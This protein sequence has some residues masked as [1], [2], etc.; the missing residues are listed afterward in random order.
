MKYFEKILSLIVWFSVVSTSEGVPQPFPDECDSKTVL[1]F[2]LKEGLTT[3]NTFDSNG[4]NF[5]ILAHILAAGNNE[6]VL[7][8]TIPGGITF[9]APNDEAIMRTMRDLGF[10]GNQENQ[11]Y[12]D[13]VTFLSKRFANPIDYL[14]RMPL[15]HIVAPQMTSTAIMQRSSFATFDSNLPLHRDGLRLIDRHPDLPDAKLIPEMQ[16]ICTSNGYIHIIDR[17]LFSDRLQEPNDP[18]KETLY[19]RSAPCLTSSQRPTI[20]PYVGDSGN[21]MITPLVSAAVEN[22]SVETSPMSYVF[23][24]DVVESSGPLV[25]QDAELKP[26]T[27]FVSSVM[28]NTLL[29][30]PRD[31]DADA[32]ML[33]RKAESTPTYSSTAEALPEELDATPVT[34]L[35]YSPQ[36]SQIPP[37]EEF[38]FHGSTDLETSPNASETP[39]D[40]ATH[41]STGEQVSLLT[42]TP[43]VIL[44]EIL[45]PDHHV[46]TSPLVEDD[47][48]IP[49]GQTTSAAP[50]DIMPAISPSVG[51]SS[52]D[53][54]PSPS[55]STSPSV[56]RSIP[57]TAAAS[58]DI[59]PS[60]TP[61]MEVSASPVFYDPISSPLIPL[62]DFE[63]LSGPV[64]P[65]STN[66]MPFDLDVMGVTGSPE[67]IIEE[68]IPQDS[69][70]TSGVPDIDGCFPSSAVIH[71]SSGQ[72]IR[73]ANLEAGHRIMSSESKSST[74]YLFS[75][76]Q[77][78]GTYPFVRIVSEHNHSIELSA[79]HYIY[80]NR[81]L[82]PA[83]DVK[84]GDILRT[85]DGPSTVKT[86][87]TV[88][89]EGLFAPHT[90]QG[91]IAVGRVIAS[92]YTS[93]L[94]HWVAHPILE[95]VRLPVRL[96]LM[97]EPLGAVLYD[98]CPKWRDF[99]EWLSAVY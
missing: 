10:E 62:D 73:M 79:E 12:Y 13:V 14:F 74:V 86:I 15:Y 87:S 42:Q 68:E 43:D 52:Q 59:V 39:S 83:I 49:H 23:D 1:E 20:A 69:P 81:Q 90:L 85:L 32:E 48:T 29:Y 18:A 97:K 47:N 3:A 37:I 22:P 61:T 35:D 64:L 67:T 58:E 98:G 38:E 27:R 93:A 77:P 95:I 89:R 56:P 75:H 53:A 26:S 94:P 9:F 16:N 54:L 30:G 71:L 21:Q 50:S 17:V 6:Q 55:L 65:S 51:G 70:A 96:G 34:D 28:P 40:T 91:D 41:S 84:R 80:A 36:P 45:T 99:R 72:D 25:F 92:S 24:T 2:I 31:L 78:L 33:V 4:T 76:R 60:S 63:A 82:K 57:R 88:Q 5:N 44:S 7:N 19:N 46:Q 66:T 8:V 11:T